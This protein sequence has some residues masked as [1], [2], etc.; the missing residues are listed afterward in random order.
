LFNTITTGIESSCNHFV[1]TSADFTSSI[2][3]LMDLSH[4]ITFLERKY[5]NVEAKLKKAF[6]PNSLPSVRN[7]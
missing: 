1:S 7:I 4:A 3:I 5:L 6:L 2:I